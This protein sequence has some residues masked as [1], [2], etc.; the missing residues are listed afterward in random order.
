L[1]YNFLYNGFEIREQER[2][3]ENKREQERTRENKREQERTRE[4]KRENNKIKINM[5]WFLFSFNFDLFP[6]SLES[7]FQNY[8]DMKYF[9]ITNII[10]GIP[11]YP[12]PC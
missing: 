9:M 1:G 7:E 2:I 12:S 3:R 8:L 6:F 10:G 11:P 4:N 5:I